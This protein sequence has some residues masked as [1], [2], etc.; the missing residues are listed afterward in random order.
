MHVG[1]DALRS[2]PPCL[3]LKLLLQT[4][5]AK[6]RAG[7]KHCAFISAAGM[8][9]G[10]APSPATANPLT[11]DAPSVHVGEEGLSGATALN[12]VVLDGTKGVA[13]GTHTTVASGVADA[14]DVESAESSPA[15]GVEAVVVAHGF[16]PGNHSQGD[17][18]NQRCLSEPSRSSVNNTANNAGTE[19]AVQNNPTTGH[20]HAPSGPTRTPKAWSV[21][22]QVELERLVKAE[23]QDIPL[24]DVEGWVRLP[25]GFLRSHSLC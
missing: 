8:D 14:V 11:G 24:A 25:V 17:T 22:E 10:P 9:A 19:L 12:G 16:G 7:E 4:A 15:A 20:A 23:G 3:K 2:R 21:D 13:A 6:R 18:A 5:R 1:L